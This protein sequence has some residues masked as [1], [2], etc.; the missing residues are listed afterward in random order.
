MIPTLLIENA[1]RDLLAA[2]AATLAPA[3]LAN[4]VHLIAAPFTPGSATDFT[5]LTPATFTGSTAKN[6]GVGTQQSFVDA[7][8]NANIVQLLEPAGGWHWQ[9]TAAPATP[10][11]IYG[12]A[13]TDNAD[14]VTFGSDL[15]DPPIVITGVGD[16]VDIPEVR[17]S[18]PLGVIT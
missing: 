1:M 6:A 16:A 4:H 3:A 2:D 15:F 12:Y 8:N 5:T 13:C 18:I 17:Y 10:E 9:C 7:V 11:T 14:A